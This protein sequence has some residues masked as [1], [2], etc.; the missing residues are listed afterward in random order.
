[1]ETIKN[2]VTRLGPTGGLFL[3]GFILIIYIAIGFLYFQQSGKQ[4]ELQD[5]INK[6]S[7]VVSRPLASADELIA[8][9]EEVSENLTPMTDSEAI[10]LLVGIAWQNGIDIDED[11]GKFRVPSASYSVA[12]VGG[13]TYHLVSFYKINVEGDPDNVMA[14]ISD[15]DSGATLP[16]M[17]LKKVVINEKIVKVGGEEQ[18]RRNE[19]R[20]VVLAVEAMMMDNNL[21]QIPNPMSA[22]KGM[23]TNL[24]G[25]D[26]EVE[27]A[28]QGFPD[29]TTTTAEKGYTG[30]GTPRNGYVLYRH[31]LI[32]P[33]EPDEYDTVSYFPTLTTQY[34]YTCEADG[35]VRQWDGPNTATA[36]EYLSMEESVIELTAILDVDIYT[37]P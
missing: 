14:F 17:V 15:L 16:T 19:F 11:S 25:D 26:P 5:Q 13:G 2:I 36:A 30:G 9:Y 22:S 23:A 20:N 27:T 18:V 28:T 1:M 3:I 6:L 7:A 33:E 29:I 24:M 10:E 31:D 12:K 4:R 8:K 21:S 32:T 37:K 34:Y 35:T